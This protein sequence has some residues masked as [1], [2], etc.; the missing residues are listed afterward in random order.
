RCAPDKRESWIA[1]QVERGIDVLI[2]HPRSVATGLDLLDF[3]TLI[4]M[5]IEYSSYVV[6]QASRRSWRIGQDRP[7]RVYFYYYEQTLQAEAI[8]LIAA[9]IAANTQVNGDVIADNSLADLAAASASIQGELAKIALGQEE[10]AQADLTA[11][12]ARANQM[13]SDANLFLGYDEAVLVEKETVAV[14]NRPI[15]AN[16]GGASLHPVP[17]PGKH[18]LEHNGTDPVAK[19][20]KVENK[21][22]TLFNRLF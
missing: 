16:G 18:T 20:V 14:V 1:R 17:I 11:L 19:P 22:L 8:Q 12:F 21:Q 2:T 4:F 15:D 7:V 10:T 3:P 5:G 6:A 9:K 13:Q